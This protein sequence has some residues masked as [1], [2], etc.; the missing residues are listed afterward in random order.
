MARA[1]LSLKAVDLLNTGLWIAEDEP[2]FGKGLNCE[3][4][5]RA[6]HTRVRPSK[7]HLCEC[8]NY[9]T[10]RCAERILYTACNKDI[11]KQADSSF[12]FSGLPARFSIHA[13]AGCDL[14]ESRGRPNEPGIPQAGGTANCGLGPSAKPDRWP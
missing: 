3:L 4:A 10:S 11:A 6:L 13:Q 8:L 7:V 2:V 1:R 5:R 14:I 9:R 12:T